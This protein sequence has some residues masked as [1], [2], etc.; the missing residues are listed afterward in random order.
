MPDRALD[1]RKAM[2]REVAVGAFL[3]AFGAAV[4]A[5]AWTIEPGVQTDPLG[6]RAFPA[7][8]GAGTVLCGVLLVGIALLGTGAGGRTG[9]IL[10][11]GPEGEV[12]AGPVS[13][14]R[15][16]GAIAATAAYV[17]LFD[18]LG[19]LLATP[20]YV[21]AIILIHGGAARRALLI[22]PP[23]VTVVLYAT[24]RFGLLIPVPEGMLDGRLPW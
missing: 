8:L 10:E 4:L 9:P 16:V 18:P 3:I 24:F 21:A 6:P 1:E 11:P 19:Y 12:E 14:A 15:L 23:L 13:P 17:A 5:L 2:R 7:A 20:P 22:A